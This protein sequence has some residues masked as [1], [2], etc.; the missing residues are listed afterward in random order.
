MDTTRNPDRLEQRRVEIRAEL[1][2]IGDLRPGSLVGRF[3][4]CGKPNCHCAKEDSRGHGPSWS[5]TR[6]VDG[7]TVTRIIPAAAVEET[8]AQIA[9]YKRL[10]RLTQ[11]LVEVSE[12]LCEAKLAAGDALDGK[13]KKRASKKASKRKSSPRLP[14]S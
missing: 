1:S 4:K 10:R 6:H 8:K 7:K 14:S 12:S 3:R 11:E 9:E 13:V 5:L 2:S